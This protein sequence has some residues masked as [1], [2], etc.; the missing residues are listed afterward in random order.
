MAPLAP[1]RFSTTK[2]CLRRS[3]SCMAVMRA[4]MSVVPPAGYGTMMRT[5]LV[6]Y[7]CAWAAAPIATSSATPSQ[8]RRILC[9]LLY[10]L[11]SIF[12]VDF[13]GRAAATSSP[14]CIC[15]PTAA[16]RPG[17]LAPSP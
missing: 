2:G 12:C 4:M 5:G 14:G 6:G 7:A 8:H 1:A 11:V 16:G 3:D 9:V 10:M 17:P 15:W 13:Y